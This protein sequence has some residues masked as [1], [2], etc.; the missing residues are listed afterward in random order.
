M[1]EEIGVGV[2]GVGGV[3]VGGWDRGVGVGE[4]GSRGLKSGG[5][6][7]KNIIYFSSGGGPHPHPFF[8]SRKLQ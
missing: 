5:S 4:L 3:G 7:I 2:N 6:K 1:S 8:F